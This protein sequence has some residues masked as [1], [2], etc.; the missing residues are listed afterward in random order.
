MDQSQM[1]KLLTALYRVTDRMEDAEPLKWRLREHALRL[2]ELYGEEENT[3]SFQELETRGKDIHGLLQKIIRMLEL[4][5]ALS[6]VSRANFDVLLREYLAFEKKLFPLSEPVLLDAHPIVREYAAV[7]VSHMQE[8]RG[9][10]PLSE[11]QEK[12]LHFLGSRL[13]S[14]VAEL[15]VYFENRI[16]EKTIQRDLNELILSGRV[17]ANGKKRW[18]KYSVFK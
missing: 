8:K 15:A 4:A 2:S 16:S 9:L 1:Q 12:I 13:S 3:L 17:L 10:E 14:N 18:R 7:K 6:F 5:S 11:R